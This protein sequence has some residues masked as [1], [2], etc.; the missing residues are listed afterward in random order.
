MNRE[1][2]ERAMAEARVRFN[3]EWQG[4]GQWLADCHDV[5]QKIMN[6]KGLQ[7]LFVPVKI[8]DNMIEASLKNDVINRN[9]SAL[10]D[11]FDIL[12]WHPEIGFEIAWREFEVLMKAYNRLVWKDLKSDGSLNM[13]MRHLTKKVSDLFVSSLCVHD[14]ELDKLLIR[15]MA[16]APL[17]MYKFAVLRLFRDF[18][19]SVDPQLEYTSDRAKDFLDHQLYDDINS[20]YHLDAANKPDD[21]TLR[22]A[23]MLLRLIVTGERKISIEGHTYNVLNLQSRIGFFISCVLYTARCERFHGDYF[24]PFKGA[25]STKGT[26]CAYYWQMTCCYVYNCLLLASYSDKIGASIGYSINSLMSA[27]ADSLNRINLIKERQQ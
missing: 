17:S 10:L 19:L 15:M 4:G 12:P 11:I 5:V 8:G 2:R 9:F 1:Q 16:E 18:E 14:P 23:A 6:D 24:S 25:M 13:D 22:R 26:F 3:N 27:A 21:D 7:T 20:K